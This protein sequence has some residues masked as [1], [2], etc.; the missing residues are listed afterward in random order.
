MAHSSSLPRFRPAAV[1]TGIVDALVL[2]LVVGGSCLIAA[3]ALFAKLQIARLSAL[4]SGGILIAWILAQLSVI[5]YVSWL[6]P[7]ILVVGAAVL[8]LATRLHL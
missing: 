2:F 7:A 4:T 6:Q 8:L 1:T 5:G 3:I